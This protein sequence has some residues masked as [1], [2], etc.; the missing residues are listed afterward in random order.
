[1]NQLKPVLYKWTTGVKV[2]LAGPPPV[3]IKT[4]VNILKVPIVERTRVNN[5]TGFIKGT[6]I[7]KKL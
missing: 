6:V 3:K 2:E 4:S 5:K 1:L 7:L